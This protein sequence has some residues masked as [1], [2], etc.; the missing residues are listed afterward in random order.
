[1][2]NQLIANLSM[3]YTDRPMLERFSAAAEYGFSGVEIQFPYDW[4][5]RELKE[6]ADKAG[7]RIHL[8][9]V[10][11]GDLLQGGRGL[12]CYDEQQDDFR[13]ACALALQYGS[14]LAVEKVNVLAGNIDNASHREACLNCYIDNLRYAAELFLSEGITLSFEAINSLD[15]PGYLYSSFDEMLAIFQKV[16]HPNAGMQ[17]DIYHMARMGEDIAHQLA[18]YGDKIAHIQFADCPGRGAPGS[19]DLPLGEYFQL[20]AASDY[21]GVVAAEYKTEGDEN[22]DYGWLIVSE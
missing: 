3:L 8:I 12:S 9:N 5:A 21:T 18:H 7:V 2:D 19:G 15:M 17:Y 11:A 22:H 14:V 13:K 10:P 20:I 4:S 16:A 1:M 6:A